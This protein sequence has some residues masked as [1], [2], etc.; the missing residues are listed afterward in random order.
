MAIDDRSAEELKARIRHATGSANHEPIATYDLAI[1]RALNAAFISNSSSEKVSKPHDEFVDL[2]RAYRAEFTDPD[3][4][5]NPG[6]AWQNR[7]QN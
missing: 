7:R 1:K 3:P 2:Y 4:R 6:P 5:A